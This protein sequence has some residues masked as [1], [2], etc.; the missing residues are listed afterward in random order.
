MKKIATIL[1]LMFF[2][3][4]CKS[5]AQYKKTEDQEHSKITD[6]NKFIVSKDD[7]WYATE[8]AQK[9]AENVLLYQ[10][11]FGGWPKNT[12]MQNQLSQAEKKQL[13]ELK[14]DP[15]GCTIDNGATV[16]EMLF[17]S[18]INKQQPNEKYKNAFFRGLM[19]LISAQ[20]ANGGFPQFF[21]LKKGYAKHITYNDDAMVNVLKLFKEIKDN[22]NYYSIVPPA[23]IVSMAQTAFDKGIDC[24]LKTQYKQKGVLTSWCA[25]HDEVTLLPADA[26][27][28]ELASLSGKE[29]AKITLLLMS[30][31]NP[32]KEIVDAVEA[33][34]LWFE[35]TKITGI[36]IENV[37]TGDGDKTDRTVVESP[38][39]E[40]LW[41]R[42]MELDNNKPFFCDRD[43]VKK[44]TLAEIGYERRNGYGWYASE[45][46]E[47]LKKYQ[48]WKS[49]IK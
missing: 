20:Y 39:A 1:I 17:L 41:A 25:Q 47:V 27:A 13:L 21:P 5:A 33:A 44:A 45:P 14:S 10:R 26:R 49:K 29:S 42:F 16:Q 32:S 31:E 8:E 7:N 37:P 22:S 35:K 28:F 9:V 48:D 19:Y 6:W 46:R 12:Q 36:K 30:I 40:P 15:N 24:I 34:V 43:G 38:D 11:D 4:S 3:V 23:E 2:T 18:K